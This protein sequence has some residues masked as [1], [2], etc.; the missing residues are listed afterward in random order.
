[1]FIPAYRDGLRASLLRHSADSGDHAERSD[2]TRTQ[3]QFVCTLPRYPGL[4][5]PAGSGGVDRWR[6]SGPRR[7]SFRRKAPTQGPMVSVTL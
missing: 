1:M 5:L 4:W 2:M 6:D 7:E 3:T